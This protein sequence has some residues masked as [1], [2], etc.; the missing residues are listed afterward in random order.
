MIL[1]ATG[2]RPDKLGG[3]STGN[4]QKLVALAI[5]HVTAF[6]PD[7]VI[8]GMALGWDQAVAQAAMELGIEWWAYLPFAGQEQRWP[9]TSQKLYLKMVSMAHAVHIVEKG[10]YAAWKMQSRNIA[11]INTCDHIIALWNGDHSG[12]TA[13]CI[14]YAE[15]KGK[16]VANVWKDWTRTQLR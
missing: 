6:K 8:S 10:G 11:M 1:A 12:G 5:K 16:P 3:Y 14:R 2:H 15:T 13:N 9:E 4:A 7:V